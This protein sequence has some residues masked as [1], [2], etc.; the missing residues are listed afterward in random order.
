MILVTSDTHGHYHYV[1]A[2]IDHA[3][4]MINSSITSVI[5]LGD[6]GFY[7]SH[8]NDFFIRKGNRFSRPVFVIDGNHEDFDALPSMVKRYEGY[9]TYLPRGTVHNIDG[10]RF[11][12][13]GGA[14]Y[15][16][17]M[18]TQ[19]GAVI[20]DQQIDM[21]LAKPASEVDIL[22]T[23]DCPLNIG[24]PNSPGCEFYGPTGFPRS[25]ELAAHFKPRL[26][27]FGHHH[28]WFECRDAHT[29][30]YGI[31]DTWKGFGLL[32]NDFKFSFV[33]HQL[34]WSKTPFFER[35]L[36]M[37]KIIRPGKPMAP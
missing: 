1:N 3:E 20:T 4:S 24:V 10:Y 28:K 26:W 35:L 34:P 37:L 21:C 19:K 2:Q 30:Y 16:D 7:K 8:L 14:S 36:I 11:L 5:H 29:H 33:N 12:A 27:L 25:D 9:L 13:L 18:N 15:M 23:H 31:A 32:D 6:F 22:L 17:A